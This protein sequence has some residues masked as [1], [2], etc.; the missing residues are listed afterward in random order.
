MKEYITSDGAS[1]EILFKLR[2]SVDSVRINGLS[3][4]TV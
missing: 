1:Y 2:D 3:I 4:Q